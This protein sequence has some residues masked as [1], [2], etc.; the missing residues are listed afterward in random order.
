[1]CSSLNIEHQNIFKPMDKLF[2]FVGAGIGAVTG[3]VGKIVEPGQ[4]NLVCDDCGV[5]CRNCNAPSTEWCGKF[6]SDG[7]SPNPADPHGCH[8][9]RCDIKKHRLKIK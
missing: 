9:C 6:G 5:C 4:R 7:V 1:M 3:A 8:V 2:G